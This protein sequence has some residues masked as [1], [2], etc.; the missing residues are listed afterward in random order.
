[1]VERIP[2]PVFLGSGTPDDPGF[3]DYKPGE[4]VLLI[5]PTQRAGKS[6]LG[7]QLLQSSLRPS[8]RAAAF[9]MKPRDRTVAH[10]QREL[11]FRETPGGP[12]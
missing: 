5:G 11:G 4:H 2:R 12:P 6:Y 3:F 9:C 8:L 1:M 10:W 7:W